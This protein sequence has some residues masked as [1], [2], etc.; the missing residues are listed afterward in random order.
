MTTGNA[1]A[2][3]RFIESPYSAFARGDLAAVFQVLDERIFWHV[4]GR[5]PLSGDNRGPRRGARLLRPVHALSAGTFRIH[6]EDILANDRRV[7]ALVTERPSAPGE[8]GVASGP[9]LDVENG[10]ATVFWQFQGD[11]QSEDEFWS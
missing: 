8:V 9:R 11:Q 3:R 7:L 5:G 6:I 4:P 2:N 1:E 10:K